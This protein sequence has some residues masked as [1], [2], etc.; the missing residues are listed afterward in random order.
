MNC[1]AESLS[2]HTQ[3]SYVNAY[4]GAVYW[5]GANGTLDNCSFVNCSAYSFYNTENV[6][7]LRDFGGAVFWFGENGRLSGSTF[8]NNIVKGTYRRGGAVYWHGSYGV[9]SGSNF[10]DN[11]DALEGS[12]VYWK[13]EFG[14]LCGSN[15]TNNSASEGGA[16]YWNGARGTIYICSFV[17]CNAT[18]LGGAVRWEANNGRL[19]GSNFTGN[20]ALVG[21]AVHWSGINGRLSGS[22]FTGNNATRDGGAVYWFSGY[23]SLS[24]SNFTGN[25]ATRYG[26]AVHWNALDG[27]LSGSSFL[28]NNAILGGAVYWTGARGILSGSNFT[29]NNASSGGAVHW[30]GNNGRLSGSNF[31]GNNATKGSAIYKFTSSSLIITNTVFGRNRANSDKIVIE[32]EGNETNNVNVKITFYGNDN[33]ANAIWNANN[34]GTISLANI[35]CE[36]SYDGIGREYK[37]FNKYDAPKAVTNT[38]YVNGSDEL[39]QSPLENAQLIDINITDSKG[40]V[41]YSI[42]NGTETKKSNVERNL[43]KAVLP[44]DVNPVNV[45]DAQGQI[46]I[47][48]SNLKASTYKISAKHQIDNYYTMTSNSDS[49]IVNNTPLINKTVDNPTPVVGEVIKYNLTVVNTG[50]ETIRDNVT[51]VDALSDG[52]EYAGNYTISD[53]SYVNF[54]Q[55][56]KV[57]TWIVTNITNSTPLVIT[58]NVKVTKAGSWTN[59]LTLNNKNYTVSA[60]VTTV[61]VNKTVDNHIPVVGEVVRYNLTVVNTGSVTIRDDVTLVDTLSDGLEYDGRY[62]L[63]GGDLVSFTRNGKVLTWIVTNITKSAPLVITVNIKVVKAGNWTNNLTLNNNFTVSENITAIDNVNSLNISK[64]TLTQ[65]VHVGSQV[66]FQID[67]INTGNVK[68]T[69]VTVYETSFD[70]LVYDSFKA[71]D[72][73]VY[74]IIRGVNAWTFKED[75]HP[76]EEISFFTVF[77]TT[78]NGTFVNNVVASSDNTIDAQANATVNVLKPDFKVEKI[79]LT[80]KVTL[81]EQA[82]YEVVV[83]N[84]GETDLTNIVVEELPDASL[85]YDHYVDKGLFKHSVVAGKHVWTLDKLTKDEYAGFILYFNTTRAG[86]ISNQIIVKCDEDPENTTVSNNTT[87][88]IPSFSLEKISL[89]PTVVLGQSVLFE[90]VIRN[91]GK[92]ELTNVYFTEDSFDGLVYDSAVGE[93]IWTHK[94]ENAKHTWTF[95]D[96]LEPDEIIT[97]T[98]R[99]NTTASGKF[100]NFVSAASDQTGGV[101]ANASVTVLK[102]EFKVEK[103]VLTPKVALG[104]QV[105][106]EIVIHNTGEANL[107][108]I[109]VEEM[110]DASLIFDH[111]V[112]GGLFKHSVVAGK[113]VWTLDKLA[114]GTYAGFILYFNTTRAGNVSNQIVVKSD[115]IPENTTVSN[116]TTVLLPAFGVEK[117]CLIP[118]VLVGN[119]TQF[120]IVIRNTGKVELTNVYFTEDSFDGLVYDSSVGEGIWIHKFENGK[121]TWTLNDVLEPDEIIGLILIFNTTAKGNFTNF[122]SAS[123]NQT[124]VLT[125]NATVHVF[126]G[127][128]PEPPVQNTTEMDVF[129][130][131]ITQEAVLGGQITFQFVVHNT[132]NKNLENVKISEMLPEGLIY[133]HFVDY[134]GL[135]MYNGDLTWSAT[136]AI[137]PGEYAGFFVTFNTTKAGKFENHIVVTANN[138][139]TTPANTSFEVL[140]PDFT[141]EKI[142]V[143]DNIVNGNQAVFEIV[144]HNT[145]SASLTN[146]TVREYFFEGLLYDHFTDYLDLWTYNGDLSWTMNAKLLPGEYVGFFVTFNTTKDG[147]FTNIVVANSSECDNKFSNT[148]VSVHNETVDI[149][150]ICLTPLVI[151]GNQAIFEIIVRNTGKVNIDNLKLSEFDYEGLIYDHYMDYLGHWINDGITWTLNSTLVPGEVTSLFVVFNTTRVGN[152]TNVVLANK[153]TA[154]TNELLSANSLE[155]GIYVSADVEVVKPEYTIEKVALNKTANIGDEVIFE[156]IVHNTGKVNITNITVRD[157]PSDGLEYLRFV[158][159]ENFWFKNGDLSW[160]LI[161]NLTSGEYSIFYVVFNA[162]KAGTL[163]NTLESDNLT[164]KATVEVNNPVVPTNPGLIIEAEIITDP[165]TGKQVLKVTVINTGDVDLDNVFVRPKLPEGLRYGDYYSYDSVWNFNNGAF[166]LEGILKVA[167]SKSFYIEILGEPGEYLIPIDGGYNNTV[168]D[169]TEVFVKILDNSTPGN[170]TPEDNVKPL[171]SSIAAGDN[172]TGNPLLMV[173]VVLIALGIT[174]FRKRD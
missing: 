86:N 35:T 146:L 106:Y 26:G 68:L 128:V 74:S 120:E 31:T 3:D 47:K 9:L 40:N 46:F 41:I 135:W 110:P 95:N 70:G 8:I 43:L 129:K 60:N 45:T 150:Q 113:H 65:N 159:G 132:G 19:S 156:I 157:I 42:V 61:V 117:I 29:G 116:N 171:K 118:N 64:I 81:G 88:V 90:I 91:T 17:N 23:G 152:F 109:V 94:F 53:G 67:V 58:V 98:L 24:G 127:K 160:N 15:F 165:V 76:G 10:T 148:S 37:T 18:S 62:N 72:L 143:E 166:D 77:N 21:G 78:T 131:V 80:P 28:A 6:V 112:D 93:G 30:S 48:L 7:S 87:V 79:V 172:A 54:T 11:K 103:I 162:T 49:F 153:A 130:I 107:T 5:Y 27:N 123:S 154:D 32:V 138:T 163:E 89:T 20:N 105:R 97:L 84:T 167:E 108:N 33:I 101:Y 133:S 14:C 52:L 1:S 170:V 122:V 126:E 141:V 13:G 59:N 92:A 144:V 51:L 36:F 115:E 168:T 16:V 82:S 173:L 140:N 142:L 139:N 73:W 39:W 38:H 44:R 71:S 155:D 124:G 121:H 56:G 119:Q 83:H 63:I 125:A 104:E 85:I 102:P 66:T 136:R 34:G 161:G 164:S 158:D 145:G 151:V 96:V 75:L 174:R 57:L 69:N 25:N 99:F 12:A 134:L 55:N 4:G 2:Y 169:S 147:V 100:T 111:Y 50:D 22:S 137:V 149:S 114:K